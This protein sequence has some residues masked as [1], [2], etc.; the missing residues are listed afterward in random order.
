MTEEIWRDVPGWESS[1][2]VS[3]L[4]RVRSKDRTTEALNPH[5][6]LGTRRFRGR[7]LHPHAAG[8]RQQYLQVTFT[9]P[10]GRRESHYVHHLVLLA[11]VGPRPVGLE[12]CHGPNGP[13]DNA[14][15]NLRYDTRSANHRDRKQFG[16]RW[17]HGDELPQAK[18]TEVA[19]REIRAR[20]PNE[21]ARALARAF[22]VAHSTI[23]GVANGTLWRH[24]A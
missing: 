6:T 19:V 8:N 11:F 20:W 4:G 12:V 5:G 18:L 17:L 24:V 7:L 21:S 1:Y 23:L 3:T 10:Y 22:G 13:A 15:P 9:G 2:Q 16:A 14:L